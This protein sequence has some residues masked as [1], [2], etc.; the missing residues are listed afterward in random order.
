MLDFLWHDSSDP[1]IERR[2]EMPNR[3]MSMRK[4]KEVLRLKFQHQFSE[5]Q[6]ARS[7]SISRGAVAEY[8]RRA[9]QAG[10]AWPLPEGLD[11]TDL[12]AQLFPVTGSTPTATKP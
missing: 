6:I 10:V 8:L 3:R 5:R 9:Q 7:C 12:E 11:D 4:I 1:C 2:N